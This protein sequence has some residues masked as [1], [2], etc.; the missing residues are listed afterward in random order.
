[1]R[2]LTRQLGYYGILALCAGMLGACTQQTS[3]DQ[4]L[5]ETQALRQ[6]LVAFDQESYHEFGSAIAIDGNFMIVGVRFDMTYHTD[7]G[8]AYLYERN[9]LGKWTL[10]KKL[11]PSDHTLYTSSKHFGAS[12]AIHGNTVVIGAPGDDY[13]LQGVNNITDVGSAYIFQ[14]NYGGSN[15]WGEVKKLIPNIPSSGYYGRKGDVFGASVA[16]SGDTVIVGAPE[17]YRRKGYAMVFGRDQNGSNAWGIVKQLRASDGVSKEQFGSS[18][19]T[20]G[21]TI[22]V[23]ANR[24]GYDADGDGRIECPG[25]LLGGP[26]CNLGS[27]YIFSRNQGGSNAWGE[28]KMLNPLGWDTSSY[29]SFQGVLSNVS[30]SSNTLV[31]GAPGTPFDLNGNGSIECA[32]WLGIECEWNVGTVY[33]FSRNKNGSNAWGMIKQLIAVDKDEYNSFGSSVSIQGDTLIVGSPGDHYD[34][35]KNGVTECSSSTTKC[36]IGSAYVFSRN[37]GGSDAWGQSKRLVARNGSEEQSFGGSVATFDGQIAIGAPSDS[38]DTL[39]Y[40]GS[41]YIFE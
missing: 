33:I 1:M 14:R 32:P 25:P 22:A 16:I 6:K 40:N 27:V 38:S 17:T 3:P 34:A 26:E 23:V 37:Q 30:M 19:T 7:D 21:D 36:N 5:L 15:H 18:V 12:V 20:Q 35:A 11:I 4:A 39:I 29:I 10:V 31:V 2:S 8:S 9:T 24:N 41:V 28:V 13:K